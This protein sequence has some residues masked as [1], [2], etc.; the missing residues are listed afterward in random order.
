MKLPNQVISG[1]IPTMFALLIATGLLPADEPKMNKVMA[2]GHP[3]AVWEKTAESPKAVVLLLHGR[4]W[5]SVPDFDLQVEGEELSLMDGLVNRGFAVYALD[6]RGYGKTPR[7]ETGWL[8]PDRASM[9]VAIVLQWLAKRH[10]TLEP[11]VVFGWSMGSMVAQLTAQRNPKLVSS[12]VLFGYPLDPFKELV[13][14]DPPEPIKHVNTAEAAASDFITP[15]S[16]S[17][18]AIKAYVE[19]CL[20]SDPVRVDWRKHAQ[21]SKLDPA[22]LDVPVLLIQAEFDPL[23]KTDTHARFFTKLATSDRQWVVIPGGDH[24]AFLETPRPLFLHVL[25]SFIDRWEK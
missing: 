22:K 20:A 6:A 21:W 9:D 3:L 23:A 12:V 25:G 4:L 13:F 7:D 17:S 19:A 5:S 14:P 15:N 10:P 16:I 2:D 1:F 8:T 11:P 18:K 24:A